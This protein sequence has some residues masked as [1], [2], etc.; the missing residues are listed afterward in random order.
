MSPGGL[1]F[2]DGLLF[3]LGFRGG[4]ADPRGASSTSPQEVPLRGSGPGG[5]GRRE[6]A[7]A[8]AAPPAAPLAVAPARR[9]HNPRRRRRSRSL[10]SPA[11][12]PAVGGPSGAV[13]KAS[14]AWRPASPRPPLPSAVVRPFPARRPSASSAVACR[15]WLPAGRGSGGSGAAWK[16]GGRR[17]ERRS[18]SRGS[19]RRRRLVPELEA[20][21][22]AGGG[23]SPEQPARRPGRRSRRASP[24]VHCFKKSCNATLIRERKDPETYGLIVGNDIVKRLAL[25]CVLN[26]YF[27]TVN[28]NYA[29]LL[30]SKTKEQEL[31]QLKKS[32]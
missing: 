12:E 4:G 22:T 20:G 13:R 15:K 3:S 1:P 10:A 17:R 5:G 26:S 28:S 29:Y 23:G 14:D 18:G 11:A 27:R 7:A 9:S 16:A 25:I 31:W 21:R 2:A 32:V 19:R 30:V 8:A 6:Q 24:E